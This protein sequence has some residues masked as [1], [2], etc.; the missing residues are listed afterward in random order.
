MASLI[1]LKLDQFEVFSGWVFD[2]SCSH[3]DVSFS[4]QECS[5]LCRVKDAPVDFFSLETKWMLWDCYASHVFME[6]RLKTWLDVN[7]H[8]SLH[9][10]LCKVNKL[11][12]LGRPVHVPLSILLRNGVCLIDQILTFL[13]AKLCVD[14]RGP[15]YL[16]LLFSS[17]LKK[18]AI[19]EGNRTLGLHGV[20]VSL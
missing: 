15:P 18:N 19:L 10:F 7:L 3:V 1:K 6:N 17:A 8:E 11:S 20:N 4:L 14:S 12:Q 2:I 16:Y 13:A 9:Q 5:S